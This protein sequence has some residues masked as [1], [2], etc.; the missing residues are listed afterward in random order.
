MNSPLFLIVT[1]LLAPSK[2]IHTAL[3]GIYFLLLGLS[4]GSGRSSSTSSRSGR[5][6][7]YTDVKSYNARQKRMGSN[8]KVFFLPDEGPALATDFKLA[9]PLARTSATLCPSSSVM[10]RATA[11][12]SA[13]PPDAAIT[14]VTCS[15]VGASF[16]PKTK[17]K[18]AAMCFIL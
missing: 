11:A 5:G 2:H 15:A 7:T 1:A 6:G 16:P 18:Y 17:S 14:S 3:K 10:R 4:R 8:G 9:F 12:S 13:A